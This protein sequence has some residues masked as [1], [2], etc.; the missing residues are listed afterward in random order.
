[1]DYAIVYFEQGIIVLNALQKIK[2][3]LNFQNEFGIEP[4]Q[5]RHGFGLFQGRA[6][7]RLQVF[8]KKLNH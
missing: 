2:R 5:K 7:K 4:V 3:I 1:L 6:R 8:L